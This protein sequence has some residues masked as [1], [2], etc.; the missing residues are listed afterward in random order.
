MSATRNLLKYLVNVIEKFNEKLK[1]ENDFGL[2]SFAQDLDQIKVEETLISLQN[3]VEFSSR[4]DMEE[5]L[6]TKNKSFLTEIQS[7]TFKFSEDFKQKFR[8]NF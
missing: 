3:Q 6:L 5:F 1:Y 2:L 8:P 7:G 4:F